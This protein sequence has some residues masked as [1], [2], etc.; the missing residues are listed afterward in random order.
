MKDGKATDVFR[1]AS[2]N[3]A[4]HNLQVTLRQTM[5][6]CFQ[7][8]KKAAA[9][10]AEGAQQMD[11]F[12]RKHYADQPR[13]MAEWDAIMAKYEFLDDEVDDQG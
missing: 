10:S 11:A 1:N 4:R 13:K 9:E 7:A 3:L 12:V 8:A 2:V 6:K 5:E